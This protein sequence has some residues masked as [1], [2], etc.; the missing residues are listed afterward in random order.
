MAPAIHA[1]LTLAM[2]PLA[3]SAK[4]ASSKP[5]SCP[6][7][8]LRP[9]ACVA[10]STCTLARLPPRFLVTRTMTTM[11]PMTT[12]SVSAAPGDIEPPPPDDDPVEYECDEEDDDDECDGAA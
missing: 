9:S 10:R 5:G 3:R 6:R 7:S 11:M 8:A 4:A 1:W 2:T 12:S